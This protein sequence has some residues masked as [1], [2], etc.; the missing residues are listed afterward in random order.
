MDVMTSGFDAQLRRAVEANRNWRAVARA[1]GLK[2]DS[3]SVVRTLKGRAARLDLDTSHFTNQRRWSDDQLRQAVVDS[4]SWAEVLG[5]LGVVDNVADRARAKGHAAR[6]DSL[7]LF[8]IVL[9][10][11]NLY[12]IPMAAIAGRTQ[13][14]PH[15]YARYRVGDASSLFAL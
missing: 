3:A 2:G 11:G 5:Y 7:D 14:Y 15:N 12:L 10:D 6:L 9:G 1:L 8:F 13:I 4:T